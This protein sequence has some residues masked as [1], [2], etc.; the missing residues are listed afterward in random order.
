MSLML[1]WLAALAQGAAAEVRAVHTIEPRPFGYFLGDTLARTVEIE[2]G[3][4]DEIVTAS[5]I[6]S[7][8]NADGIIDAADAA[9]YSQFYGATGLLAADA[10]RDG[11]VNAADYTVW[12]DA[13]AANPAQAIPEPAGELLALLAIAPTLRRLCA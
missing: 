6:E 8:L 3:P 10:N 5:L 13:L 12:R 4:E 11:V 2:T 9:T 7:D 1:A